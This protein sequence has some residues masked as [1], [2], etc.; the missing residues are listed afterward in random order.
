MVKGLMLP[1]VACIGSLAG[2]VA[3]DACSATFAP[4]LGQALALRCCRQYGVLCKLADLFDYS[5]GIII[6]Y[7]GKSLSRSS[8][9][10]SSPLGLYHAADWVMHDLFALHCL[11]LAAKLGIKVQAPVKQVVCRQNKLQD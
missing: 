9:Y 8:A 1:D 4:S 7:E 11:P 5:K 2:G 3:C 10:H 6:D